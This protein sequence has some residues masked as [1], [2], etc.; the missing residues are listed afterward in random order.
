MH[1]KTLGDTPNFY[2]ARV[3]FLNVSKP[4]PGRPEQMVT[5]IVHNMARRGEVKQNPEEKPA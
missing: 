4:E 1:I 5:G 3:L 2:G